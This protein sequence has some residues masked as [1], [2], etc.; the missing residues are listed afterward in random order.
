MCETNPESEAKEKCKRPEIY[1]SPKRRRL[2][3]IIAGAGILWAIGSICLV[4]GKDPDWRR[5][6]VISWALLPP[7]FFWAEYFFIFDNW[8]CS[9]AVAEFKHAQ[10]LAAKVWAGIAGLLVVALWKF[11]KP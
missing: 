6:V 11:T 1:K 3:Q 10:G 2:T 5:V 4:H 7:I 9:K 8:G